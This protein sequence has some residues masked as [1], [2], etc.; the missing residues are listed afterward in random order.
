MSLSIRTL[1]LGQVQTNCY[2]VWNTDTKEGIVIDPADDAAYITQVI[3]EEGVTLQ[4]IYLTHG[5]FDHIMAA[6]AVAA[7]HR[8]SVYCLEQEK[9]LAE[10]TRWNLSDYF[11]CTYALVPDGI[12]A[13]GVIVQAAGMPMQVLHTPGHTKGSGCYYFAEEG[14]LFSGDTLFFESVGRTDFPTGNASV[15]EQ[16]IKEK[17]YVLPDTVTVY[18]GHGNKTSIGYEKKNNMLVQL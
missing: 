11:G 9:E 5:H 10:S 7:A 4:A 2:L 13:D 16:S 8:V 17:L 15:L 14:I 18:P 12:L 3:E 6:S 1:V